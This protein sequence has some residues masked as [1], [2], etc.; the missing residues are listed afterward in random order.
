MLIAQAVTNWTYSDLRRRIVLPVRVAYGAVPQR[1]TELLAAALPL[2]GLVSLLLRSQL[3][4]H[5]ENYR[6]HFV[7]FGLAGTLAFVLGYGAGEA[8]RRRGDGC[9][10]ARG[11]WKP[12]RRATRRR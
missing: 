10:R 4:P 1:V 2:I 11:T 3:D 9:H 7:L 8:A 6:L 12:A 5:L